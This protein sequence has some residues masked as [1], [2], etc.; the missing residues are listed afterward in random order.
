[1][2]E[3]I[4]E[5]GKLIDGNGGGQPFFSEKENVSGIQQALDTQ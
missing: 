3:P 2:Q 4:R 1:M 5:L